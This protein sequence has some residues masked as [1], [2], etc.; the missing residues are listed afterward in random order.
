MDDYTDY[1]E[2]QPGH[3]HLRLNINRL[4]LDDINNDVTLN[5]R[6]YDNEDNRYVT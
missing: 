2:Y 3:L 5:S 4:C 1:V 6:E